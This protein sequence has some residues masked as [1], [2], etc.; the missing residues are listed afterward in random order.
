[1]KSPA[2]MCVPTLRASHPNM[3]VPM[4]TC[5]VLIRHH[6]C[7]VVQAALA[8]PSLSSC[9]NHQLKLL[10]DVCVSMALAGHP[11]MSAPMAMCAVCPSKC[12]AHLTSL[13]LEHLASHAVSRGRG[14]AETSTL[15]STS[16][17]PTKQCTSSRLISFHELGCIDTPGV[18]DFEGSM[19]FLESNS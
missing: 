6:G 18:K 3:S 13:P 19:H 2:D 15:R 16:S 4:A 9:M 5:A 1:L 12:I 17:V 10:G 11:S 14:P 7:V 8:H